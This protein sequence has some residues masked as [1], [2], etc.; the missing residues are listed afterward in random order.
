MR[1]AQIIRSEQAVRRCFHGVPTHIW[2]WKA[3]LAAHGK[4]CCVT[5][6]EADIKRALSQGFRFYGMIYSFVAVVMLVASL[7]TFA[8]EIGEW[9]FW[10]CMLGLAGLFVLASSFL[11]F[12]GARLYPCDTK[13]ASALLI[14][15][16]ISIMGFLMFFLGA[17]SVFVNQY[18]PAAGVVALP[19]ATVL[20]LIG[21]GSY[22][23]EVL[24]LFFT[25]E[26]RGDSM[27]WLCGI[28]AKHMHADGFEFFVTE[29]D[30]WLVDS[31]PADYLDFPSG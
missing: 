29:S 4:P 2:W 1:F 26:G 11:A 22:L 31:I 24:Y 28:D 21:V 18:Q 3:I 6:S 12:H 19:V 13:Q 30:M 9:R 17:A 7:M 10:S 27:N 5:L 14:V 15:F 8:I 16:F 23:I 20:V 25:C